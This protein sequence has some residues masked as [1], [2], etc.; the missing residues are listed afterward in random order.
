MKSS[1]NKFKI[2][3]SVRIDKKARSSSGE[4]KPS[5]KLIVRVKAP[6]LP[7]S[8]MLKAFAMFDSRSWLLPNMNTF[9][10]C[11]KSVHGNFG[12]DEGT[13]AAIE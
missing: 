1:Y 9:K 5:A 4:I 2:T 8:R 7:W 11:M 6:F 3:S 12:A 10:T 13:C